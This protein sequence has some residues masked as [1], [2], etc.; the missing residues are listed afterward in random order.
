VILVRASP[1]A[2]YEITTERGQVTRLTLSTV[3]ADCS[4]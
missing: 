1:T 2:D 4:G 3:G